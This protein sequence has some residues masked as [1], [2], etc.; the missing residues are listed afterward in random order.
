MAAQGQ[1]LL[2][3]IEN[4]IK[5]LNRIIGNANRT[6]TMLSLAIDGPHRGSC[7]MLAFARL[8]DSRWVN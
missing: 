8:G 4:R 7:F 5:I 6:T 3:D 1:T 2:E